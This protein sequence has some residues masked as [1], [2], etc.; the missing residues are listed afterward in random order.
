M[1][2]ILVADDDA[3][4]QRLLGVIL[5]RMGHEVVGVADGRDALRRVGEADVDLLIVDLSMPE[6]D[7]VTVVRTLRADE[8][9]RDL[10]VIVLTASGLDSDARSARA[11]GANEFLT[12]PVRT[13]ELAAVLDRLLHGR[14]GVRN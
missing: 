12:K 4:N 7:G 13:Q 10:P 11:A 3:V 14:G 1:A 6:I 9:H 2:T 8:R 5:G